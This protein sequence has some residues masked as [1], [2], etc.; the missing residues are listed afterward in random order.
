MLIIAKRN[1]FVF[2][3]DKSNVLFSFL[4]VF[5][6]LG[7]YVMF[8]GDLMVQGMQDIT[9]AAFLINSWVMAGII[10]V[11][12]VTSTLGAFGIMVEDRARKTIKDFTAAPIKR[13]DIAGGYI[14][15]VFV[16]GVIMSLIALLFAEL[17]IVLRGGELLPLMSL[18]KVIAIIPLAVLAS[19]SI[20]FF[21]TSF[22]SSQNAFTT[23]ST[24][25][26]T[27]IGFLTGIYIPIGSLPEAVQFVIKVFPVSHAASLLRSIM[28]ER[29][30]DVSFADAPA[31]AVASFKAD[32]GVHYQFGEMTTTAAGS[33]AVLI[34][35]TIL[36]YALSLINISRKR[37]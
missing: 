13:S 37:K 24:I 27:L 11:T 4:A 16:I 1:L 22:I 12:S 6:I 36:F 18:L 30:M 3:R 7:L 15:S 9:G 17:Y 5:I 23:I 25:I 28:L 10:A 8:L 21:I 29:P 14:V 19:S 35:T 26:G 31:D 20:V 2:F 34:A 32:M 33:V